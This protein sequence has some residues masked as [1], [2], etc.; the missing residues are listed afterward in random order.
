MS[1][2]TAIWGSVLLTTVLKSKH[3]ALALTI[4][5]LAGCASQPT[6]VESPR[7]TRPPVRGEPI[8]PPPPRTELAPLPRASQGYRLTT[9]QD[10]FQQSI[11]LY[12]SL[13]ADYT[14]SALK[15]QNAHLWAPPAAQGEIARGLRPNEYLTIQAIRSTTIQFNTAAQQFTCGAECNEAQAIRSLEDENTKVVASARHT[16]NGLGILFLELNNLKPRA[17]QRK[18]GFAAFISGGP[19]APNE[20]W[21]VSVRSAAKNEA[22]AEPVWAEFRRVIVESHNAMRMAK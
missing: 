3:L 17:N 14:Y 20:V 10:A 7:D 6:R 1:T 22:G 13:P 12:I 11:P 2:R 5:T 8:D 16:I 21:L 19:A 9:F 18:R 15:T 4:A